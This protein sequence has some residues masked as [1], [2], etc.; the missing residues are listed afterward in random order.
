MH[1]EP[2][3]MHEEPYP[4]RDLPV[5]LERLAPSIWSLSVCVCVCARVLVLA[6]EHVRA[7][8]RGFVCARGRYPFGGCLQGKP[9]KRH[10]F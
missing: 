8:V 2:K 7:C 6:L 4:S 9:K 1:S 5:V 3:L 10:A